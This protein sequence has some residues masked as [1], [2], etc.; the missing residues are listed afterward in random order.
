[1]AKNALIFFSPQKAP[2][3]GRIDIAVQGHSYFDPPIWLFNN[4]KA[5]R[6]KASIF[7]HFCVKLG[8]SGLRDVFFPD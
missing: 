4:T 3:A 5:Y 8:R 6:E 7:L 2:P 1:M